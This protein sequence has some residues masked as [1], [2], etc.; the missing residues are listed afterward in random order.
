VYND[1]T[2]GYPMDLNDHITDARNKDSRVSFRIPSE[3]V[4]L[5][6]RAAEARDTTLTDFVLSSAAV[7]AEQALADRRWFD[8]PADAWAAFE[9]A[10]DRP[11]VF[12]P[13]LSETVKRDD[14]FVD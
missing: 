11:A 9:A 13:R 12:K 1:Y 2:E 7:A 8:L 6:K 5:L 10:L 3:Q 14:F 4:V